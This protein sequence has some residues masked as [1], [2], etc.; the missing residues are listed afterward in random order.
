MK[1]YQEIPFYPI[2]RRHFK[3]FADLGRTINRSNTYVS[4]CLNGHRDFSANEKRLI[5][6]A[7]DMETTEDNYRIV[8][9]EVP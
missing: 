4:L 7:M 8:F 1:H 9:P 2:I 6:E 5:L 3:S